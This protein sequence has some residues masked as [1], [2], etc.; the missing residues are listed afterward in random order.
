M[1]RSFPPYL[2]SRIATLNMVAPN[3]AKHTAPTLY[4]RLA[5][6]QLIRKALVFA[7]PLLVFLLSLYFRRQFQLWRG[8]IGLEIV[9]EG[10]GVFVEME[11]AQDAFT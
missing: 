8:K 1:S 10:E 4:A 3:S 5:S 7:P 9:R 11:W 2:F 6:F